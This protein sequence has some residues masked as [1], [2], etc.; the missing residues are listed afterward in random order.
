MDRRKEDSRRVMGRRVNR[1]ED[2]KGIYSVSASLDVPFPFKG[3]KQIVF[4]RA[5]YSTSVSV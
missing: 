3:V 2:I 1:E 5:F 4:A